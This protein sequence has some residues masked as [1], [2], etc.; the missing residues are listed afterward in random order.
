MRGM[1]DRDDNIRAARVHLGEVRAR[2]EKQRGFA[3]VLL[4]WA[5]NARRRA[6]RAVVQR[7]LFA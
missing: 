2:R 4:G 3:F 7:E 6:A 1:N 5:A